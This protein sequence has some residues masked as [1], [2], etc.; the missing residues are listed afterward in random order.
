M[1]LKAYIAETY[2]LEKCNSSKPRSPKKKNLDQ[3][4]QQAGRGLCT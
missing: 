3:L 2:W 1:C 4:V